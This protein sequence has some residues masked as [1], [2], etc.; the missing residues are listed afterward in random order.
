M[1]QNDVEKIAAN[2]LRVLANDPAVR[3]SH[4]A[5][6]TQAA[7]V[8]LVNSTVKPAAPLT[9][10][11]ITAFNAFVSQP[12]DATTKGFADQVKVLGEAEADGHNGNGPTNGDGNGGNGGGGDHGGGDHGGGGG[13]GNGHGN[14]Q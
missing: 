9:V 10:H 4:W 7:F 3:K 14:G 1:D 11:D 12:T 13:G 6:T 5:A 8:A 2:Y